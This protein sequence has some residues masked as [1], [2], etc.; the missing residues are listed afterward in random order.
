MVKF[1]IKLK[2]IRMFEMFD[3]A[4]MTYHI[5]YSVKSRYHTYLFKDIHV[6]KIHQMLDPDDVLTI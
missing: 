4:I 6:F 5:S 3:N 2:L 1:E